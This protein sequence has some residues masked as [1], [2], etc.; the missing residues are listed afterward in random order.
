[1]GAWYYR[2]HKVK[3]SNGN[4]FDPSYLEIYFSAVAYAFSLNPMFAFFYSYYKDKDYVRGDKGTGDGKNGDFYFQF[5][6]SHSFRII[7]KTYLDLDATAGFLDQNRYVMLLET[8]KSADICD[9]DLSAGFTT[10]AGIL[11]LSS[12]FHYVLVPGT[13]YKYDFVYSTDKGRWV[14][15]TDIHRFYAKF[16]VSCSI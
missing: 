2:Q 12:S 6:I 5:G 3:E 16:G 8:T 14:Y 15:D 4:T 9:I 1:M 13:Q 11:T 10:T 7:D